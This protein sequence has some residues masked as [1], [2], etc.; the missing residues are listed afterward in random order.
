MHARACTRTH[1]TRHAE[2]QTIE[3]TFDRAGEGGPGLQNQD[4]RGS[5]S[6]GE[7]IFRGFMNYCDMVKNVGI[8]PF[9]CG[10]ENLFE[11]FACN[12]CGNVFSE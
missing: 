12:S 2:T 3:Q 10:F 11:N 5:G 4:R 1:T 9:V 6:A 7:C 8:P